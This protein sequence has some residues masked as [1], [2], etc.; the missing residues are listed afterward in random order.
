MWVRSTNLKMGICVRMPRIRGSAEFMDRLS[1]ERQRVDLFLQLTKD[2]MSSVRAMAVID[3]QAP[4][5]GMD[6]TEE[7]DER[8]PES[9]RL[10]ETPAA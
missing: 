4:I 2:G 5:R 7:P 1:T 9:R 3:V 10:D 6:G 8:T